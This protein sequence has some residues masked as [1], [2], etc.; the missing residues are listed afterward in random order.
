MGVGLTGLSMRL[1]LARARAQE[2]QFRG[3][4]P[5]CRY[6]LGPQH[7]G[8]GVRAVIVAH[9]AQSLDPESPFVCDGLVVPRGEARR[10]HRRLVRPDSRTG[11]YIRIHVKPPS[12][13]QDKL[14]FRWV[15]DPDLSR[16]RTGDADAVKRRGEPQSPEV[17]IDAI[18]PRDIPV[19]RA[20]SE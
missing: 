7:C 2:C 20:G 5:E 6:G 11:P 17:T 14:C 18:P 15:E 8:F 12:F 19:T 9:L 16:G 4:R 1:R 13:L 3:A 10:Q